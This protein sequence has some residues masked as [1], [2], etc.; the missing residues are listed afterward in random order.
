[1]NDGEAAFAAHPLAILGKN[2]CVM[3]DGRFVEQDTPAVDGTGERHLIG[4]E[5]LEGRLSPNLI[6]LVA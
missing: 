6:W 2:A 3:E 1:M 4:M 5:I